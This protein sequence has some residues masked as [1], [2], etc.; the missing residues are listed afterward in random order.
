MG[1]FSVGDTTPYEAFNGNLNGFNLN[2]QKH[3]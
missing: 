3:K 2:P 1:K